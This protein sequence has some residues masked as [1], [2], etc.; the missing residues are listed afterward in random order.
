M[1]KCLLP[2]FLLAASTLGLAQGGGQF[3]NGASSGS[4]GAAVSGV[5][6]AGQIAL[7]TN[8]TTL[9]G[10]STLP[11]LTLVGTGGGNLNLT[12]GTSHAAPTNGFGL[13]APVSISIGYIWTV[14]SVDCSG[15]LNVSSDLITCLPGAVPSYPENYLSWQP[16]TLY[17]QTLTGT[18]VFA[19]ATTCT[20]TYPTTF[21]SV[22][23]VQITPVNPGAVTFT[24]TTSSTTQIIITASGSNSLT[25]NYSAGLTAGVN[26]TT[27]TFTL[28][29]A[30]KDIDFV[31]PLWPSGLP[32]NLT[33][34]MRISVS[35]IIEVRLCNP[36]SATVTFSTALTFGAKLFR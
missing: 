5:P 34:V 20:V 10:V 7:W 14:P 12:Q 32:A 18:C 29:G 23:I 15:G 11:S 9:Q 17:P 27:N 33:G 30:R 21:A 13:Q 6:T 26:C 25:V 35:D 1:R 2:L 4:G 22:P 28:S 31:A 19:A 16:G 3:G 36:T 8:S 24:I